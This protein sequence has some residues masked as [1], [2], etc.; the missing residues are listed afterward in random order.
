MKIQ[1]SCR[2]FFHNPWNE[3]KIFLD[4]NKYS[5]YFVLMDENIYSQCYPY[6]LQKNI[7]PDHHFFIIP[8]G[9]N[10]KSILSATQFWDWTLSKGIERNSLC[11]A[12]G[13]GMVCDLL[14]FC[15]SVLKR[16]ID[17]CYVPTSLMA[18]VD[19]SIGGKTGINFGGFK[20]Q[21][22]SFSQPMSVV[23]DP[24]F[25][26]TLDQRNLKNGFVEMV[27]H[28][29][30]S[31]ANYWDEL[32]VVHWPLKIENIEKLIEKSINFKTEIVVKDFYEE[33]ERKKLNFGHTFGHAIESFCLSQNK[34]ILHGEA[35]ALGMIY[36]L[37]LSNRL[38]NF[39]KEKMF[40]IIDYLKWFALHIKFEGQDIKEILISMK[41]D[42][43][44][45][46][47]IL[48][49]SLLKDIGQPIINCAVKEEMILEILGLKLF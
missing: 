35:I 19:A 28:S 25:L 23:I 7:F 15:A 2:I 17:C 1:K 36:E 46:R 27:K 37:N 41:T 49:F 6:F 31:D 39:P 16:G 40:E 32:R 18:M 44:V 43:K 29:L 47:G 26:N 48:E 24:Y 30:L 8:A 20:N 11:I 45:N 4:E 9:E 21:V 33:A 5:S 38:F 3:I 14:G 22:G 34:D 10:S 13:G 12:L 42:K